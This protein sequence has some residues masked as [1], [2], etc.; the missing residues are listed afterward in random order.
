MKNIEIK[1]RVD[2]LDGLAERA[3]A[4]GFYFGETLEQEDIYF[5]VSRGR[6]KLRLTPARPG[7][8]I[9][10]ERPDTAGPKE[11]VYEIVP[12][13]E[14]GKLAV[15]LG[16]ALGVRGKVV[17]TRQVFLRDNIRLHLDQVEGV[18]SFLELEAVVHERNGEERATREIADL[19]SRLGIFPTALMRE[20]YMDLLFAPSTPLRTG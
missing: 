12:V 19:L 9:F 15:L 16:T 8:L 1:A 3:R 14:G 13:E 20:S 18:G 5:T 7:Q 10:Y 6:L 4:L 2:R 17:K 11:S